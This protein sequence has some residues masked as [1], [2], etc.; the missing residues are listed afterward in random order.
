MLTLTTE[1]KTW[2]STIPTLTISSHSVAIAL[3]T[4]DR[5]YLDPRIHFFEC[6][7]QQLDVLN[8]IH[9][10][11]PD[12]PIF[13]ASHT[14]LT[15]IQPI[16]GL[17]NFTLILMK[18]GL[19]GN[20]SGTLPITDTDLDLAANSRYFHSFRIIAEVGIIVNP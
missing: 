5:E 7:L 17:D 3:A 11:Y 2:A 8:H 1:L 12:G 15:I 20:H 16:V 14:E 19:R 9:A 18:S 6:T 13:V 10:D 4:F